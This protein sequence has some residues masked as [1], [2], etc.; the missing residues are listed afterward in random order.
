MLVR[1][2]EAPARRITAQDHKDKGEQERKW[3]R[4]VALTWNYDL[5]TSI[6]VDRHVH[7]PQRFIQ[8][9]DPRS[10]RVADRPL[11]LS[12]F[13]LPAARRAAHRSERTDALVRRD[14]IRLRHLC[15]AGH[16]KDS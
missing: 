13:L 16:C 14:R 10:A 11:Q 2:T 9:S 6:I 3:N 8:P 5:L 12:L 7:S 4:E 15:R 1:F